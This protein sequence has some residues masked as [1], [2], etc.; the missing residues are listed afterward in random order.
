MEEPI[1][2]VGTEMQMLRIDL[3]IQQGK[4]RGMNWESQWHVRNTM[5]EIS[6]GRKLL[7]SLVLCDDLE[8]GLGGGTEGGLRGREYIC[9][10]IYTADSHGCTAGT[11][12]CKAIILQLKKESKWK[13]LNFKYFMILLQNQGKNSLYVS[14]EAHPCKSQTKST[15]D[16][17]R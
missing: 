12:P 13:F 7:H 2:R 15:H 10:C 3:W 11:Q 6:G 8:G 14:S 4:K 1:C 5:C 16:I 9:V 17:L